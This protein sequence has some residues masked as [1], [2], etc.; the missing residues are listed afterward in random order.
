MTYHRAVVE[1][2]P[3]SAFPPPPATVYVSSERTDGT[4]IAALI[5]GVLAIPGALLSG[6]FGVLPGALAIVLGLI[7]RR[8]IK[9]SGG[10]L[11][12]G[13]L[14]TAGWILGICGVLIGGIVM[15]VLILFVIAM[16]HYTY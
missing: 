15:V 5:L 3:P 14:A 1:P 7:A 12:G 10:T 9:E 13:G 6:V 2:P 8:R 11:G 4:A 16:N